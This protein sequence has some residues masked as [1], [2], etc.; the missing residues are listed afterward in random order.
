[1]SHC[2]PHSKLLHKRDSDKV[3]AQEENFLPKYQRVKDLC[4]RAEY[5]TACEQLGQV[6]RRGWAPG[7]GTGAPL[8]F[9]LSQ[10]LPLPTA[11]QQVQQS[12]RGQCPQNV[13]FCS[14]VTPRMMPVTLRK[15][16]LSER[17]LILV[18]SEEKSLG[19][20]GSSAPDPAL[21]E[22]QHNSAQRLY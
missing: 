5:R 7:P 11:A 6:R 12:E 15:Q 16:F 22:A 8:P 9:L 14:H 10:R 13:T 19:I 1:M 3:D 17:P 2:L 21:T 18:T 20:Q 4:Q